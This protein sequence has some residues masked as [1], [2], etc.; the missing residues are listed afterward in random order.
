MRVRASEH[1][2]VNMRLNIYVGLCEC[3]N[4]QA[5]AHIYRK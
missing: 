4:V 5:H 3:L 1:A 2:C